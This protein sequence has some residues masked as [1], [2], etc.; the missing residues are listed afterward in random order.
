MKYLSVRDSLPG[1][2]ILTETIKT[3]TELDIKQ[4]ERKRHTIYARIDEDMLNSIKILERKHK[5]DRSVI[6][7]S[8]IELGLKE[9]K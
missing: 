4:P 3:M 5:I 8:L 1:L 9:L 6:V 2:H 7:R